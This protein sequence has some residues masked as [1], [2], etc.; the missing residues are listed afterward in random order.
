MKH[1]RLIIVCAVVG[2]SLGAGAWFLAVWSARRAVESAL[3]GEGARR[4]SDVVEATLG[5]VL[6]RGKFQ[7]APADA[8]AI[9]YY[10]EH[11]GELQRDKEYFQTWHSALLIAISARDHKQV[12][13]GWTTSTKIPWISPSN[14][15]DAWGHPFCILSS[16]E[17]VVVVSPGPLAL[18]SLDCG[19]LRITDSDLAKMVPDRLNIE[20]SGALVLQTKQQ[21]GDK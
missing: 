2:A 15:T 8:G 19:T 17:R 11:P 7:S 9:R 4:L 13:E 3:N 10:E 6:A 20:S 5:N 18:A 1:I 12:I 21:T 16:Q 14:Q